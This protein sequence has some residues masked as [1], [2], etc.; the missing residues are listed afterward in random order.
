[1][2]VAMARISL[3]PP[4]TLLLRLVEWYSR[5]VYGALLEPGIALAH[6]RR[7][8]WADLRLEQKVARFSKLDP[9]LKELA[10]MTAAARIGCS[11]CMDFG[12]WEGHKLGI[13]A[14]K[15]RA[16]PAWRENR[17]QFTDLEA[18]VM[19]YADAMCE[20]Q[21]AVTDDMAARLLRQLGEPAF[22]ELTFM[23]GLE[24]LRSRVNSALGLRSQGFAERCEVPAVASAR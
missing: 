24:N 20:S 7:A 19:E 22:V 5:R 1:M 14:V 10:V 16:V 21:P 6:N 9:G 11:W 4:R 12:Y 3:D 13:P 18:L 23:V 17:E 2:E 8:L 15:L